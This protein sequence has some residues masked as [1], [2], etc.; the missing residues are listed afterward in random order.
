M[1]VSAIESAVSESWCCRNEA[2]ERHSE[3]LHIG[4]CGGERDASNIRLVASAVNDDQ[5]LDHR[6][7]ADSSGAQAVSTPAGRAGRTVGIVACICDR[8]LSRLFLASECGNHRA[9]SDTQPGG[10]R[11]RDRPWGQGR[12]SGG[13]VAHVPADLRYAVRVGETA[14]APRRCARYIVHWYARL[15]VR[16]VPRS[17]IGLDWCGA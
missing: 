3:A 16:K 14:A 17:R 7:F 4:R 1:T 8:I 2:P 11:P 5:N 15:S 12:R 10:E 6:V 9:I 13:G